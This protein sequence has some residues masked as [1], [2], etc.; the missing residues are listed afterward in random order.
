MLLPST[1]Q[2][3]Y[4][5]NQPVSFDTSE[6]TTMREMFEVRSARALAPKP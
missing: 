6:V 4:A 2:F 3:A 1:R 5:F